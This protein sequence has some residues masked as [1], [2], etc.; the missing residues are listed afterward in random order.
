MSDP[1]NQIIKNA[2]KIFSTDI[3]LARI[4]IIFIFMLIPKYAMKFSQYI[5]LNNW[6]D[7]FQDFSLKI[8]R[9]KREELKNAKNMRKANNF[10][11]MLLEAEAE[12]QQMELNNGTK[13]ET[14]DEQKKIT[15][16]KLVFWVIF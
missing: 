12:N 3:N 1:N 9:Q 10:L 5:G 4:A 2:K 8:I 15:K 11:E 7:F 14:N 16:C 13:I 6:V